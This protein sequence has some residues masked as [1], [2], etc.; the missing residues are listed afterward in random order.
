[1]SRKR[2]SGIIIKFIAAVLLL[3]LFAAGIAFIYRYT[4]GF[5]EDLKTFYLE[6]QGEKILTGSNEMSFSLGCQ[7]KFDVKYTFDL[8][9][10]VRD[11]T[12]K[13]LPNEDESFDYTVDGRNFLWS[14]AGETKD[15]SSFFGLKKEEKSFTLNIPS[16]LTI[17]GVLMKIFPG[18]DVSVDTA[19]LEGKNLYR[20][21]VSS[22]NGD[23]TYIINFSVVP[24]FVKLDRE[25]LTF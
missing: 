1:M 12:V 13:V 16:D 4:N 9:D 10:E 8:G 22:Y 15:L 25:Y 24:G 5:N 6:Y 3:A 18:Q 7:Q 23:I 2:T 20:L 21:E 11:Y 14:A 19:A 17:S